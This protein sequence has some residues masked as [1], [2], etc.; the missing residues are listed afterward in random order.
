LQI[1]ILHIRQA[2]FGKSRFIPL[3]SSTTRALKRYASRRDQDVNTIATDAFFVFDHGRPALTRKIQYAFRL[4]CR[5]LRWHARGGHRTPRIHDLRHSFVCRRLR[6]W[7]EEGV[8]INCNL[9]ALSTY[10]GHAKVTD[11]Y[12]YITAVPELMAIA[13]QRLKP[14]MPTGGEL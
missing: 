2:K 10:I 3:H 5:H 7:Y 13:A 8:D 12:W 6:R 14:L 1:G 9:L 4:V 11:T